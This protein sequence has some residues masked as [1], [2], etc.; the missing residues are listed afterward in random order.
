MKE[1]S[2]YSQ[3]WYDYFNVAQFYENSMFARDTCTLMYFN[4]KTTNSFVYKKKE[5][6]EGNFRVVEKDD[7]FNPPQEMMDEG[8][9]ERVERKIDVWYE[10]V[11]VM[12]TNIM[13]KWEM[14]RV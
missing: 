4:Y 3:A 9:F 7:Q 6:P 5:T 11:M 14:A 1:I 10:G 2:K 13:L 8:N 12:G